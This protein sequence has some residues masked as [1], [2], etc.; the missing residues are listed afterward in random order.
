MHVDLP[1]EKI[2]AD[3]INVKNSEYYAGIIDIE[4]NAPDLADA[5]NAGY[6][7]IYDRDEEDKDAGEEY[8]ES[9]DSESDGWRVFDYGGA[10]PYTERYTVLDPDGYSFFIS[11]TGGVGS[12]TEDALEGDSEEISDALSIE[13]RN[14]VWKPVELTQSEIANNRIVA[15]GLKLIKV[16]YQYEQD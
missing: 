1:R 14:K 5:V 3:H 15:K 10:F 8:D 12:F 4:L 2:V 13:I 6:Q 11:H 9:I 7:S 16:K